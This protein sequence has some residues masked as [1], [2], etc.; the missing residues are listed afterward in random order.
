MA[1]SRIAKIK[2][3]IDKGGGLAKTNRYFVTI[4][5][6][7]ALTINITSKKILEDMQVLCNETELPGRNINTANR[8]TFGP[9]KKV[10]YE[11]LYQEITLNFLCRNKMEEKKFFQKWMDYIANTET[12]LVKYYDD[13]V[14][15][16]GITL[17][18]NTIDESITYDVELVEAFPVSVGNQT[19]TYEQSTEIMRLPVNFAY[20]RW[21]EFGVGNDETE[22]RPV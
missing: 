10:A 5:P 4:T 6:P 11:N 15:T 13:Y 20:H 3:L 8:L 22:F 12:N 14:G 18:D 19:I 2:G 1:I 9:I 21:R 16:V 7:T 17:I